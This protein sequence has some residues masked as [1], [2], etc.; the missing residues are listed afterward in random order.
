[1]GPHSTYFISCSLDFVEGGAWNIVT[2]DGDGN[3]SPFKGTFKE[4]KAPERLAW[5]FMYDMPP[6]NSDPDGGLE[7]MVFTEEGGVTTITATSISNSF[8]EREQM[9]A[10]G[11]AEGAA[12]TW[13]R[14]EEYA[15]TLGKP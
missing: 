4:I 9:L 15:A 7:T 8:E 13:D 10:P 5:T 2:K 14:L 6:F 1:M 11:M 3:T 12:Q